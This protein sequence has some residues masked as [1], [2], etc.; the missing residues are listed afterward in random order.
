MPA[1][2]QNCA[3]ALKAGL[4]KRVTTISECQVFIDPEFGILQKKIVM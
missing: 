2:L 1:Q 4:K 3:N